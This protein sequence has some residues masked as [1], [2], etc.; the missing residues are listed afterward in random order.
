MLCACSLVHEST[1]VYLVKV[2]ESWE[3]ILF[4]NTQNMNQKTNWIFCIFKLYLLQFFFSSSS[5]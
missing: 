5:N 3:V 4:E 1:N 2:K